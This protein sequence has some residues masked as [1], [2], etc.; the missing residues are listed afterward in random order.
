M[1]TSLQIEHMA[2]IDRV[3]LTP[4]QGFLVLSGETG[5]GKSIII[6]AVN[7]ALGERGSREVIRT[8]ETKAR[9]QALFTV[10]D[11]AVFTEHGIDCSDGEVLLSRELYQDGRSIF[12]INGELSTASAVR[13]IAPFLLNIHG[14]HDN[15]MLLQ[16]ARH[17]ELVDRF[18]HNRPLREAYRAA[19]DRAEELRRRLEE[20]GAALEQ[21]RRMQ[22]LYQYQSQEIEDAQLRPGEEAEL[23]EQ[24]RRLEHGETLRQSMDAAYEYLY[25]T[26]SAHDSLSRAADAL[27][28]V[29]EY[30]KALE[31]QMGMLEEARILLDEA[32]H[33]LHAYGEQLDYEPGALDQAQD[34]FMK[35][36]QLE[37]KY[38]G[39]EEAVIAYGKEIAE[40]LQAALEG[41]ETLAHLRQQLAEAEG[42][43]LQAAE[44]LTQSRQDAAA[45]L[46]GEV[47]AQLETLDMGKMRF[48]VQLTP[49]E[50][51]T[52]GAEKCVFLLSS[53][54]GEEPKELS[55]IASGGEL[56][57]IMLAM[58]SALTDADP[59][60]T[61]IFDEIDTGVSGRAA[62]KIAEKLYALSRHK[63]VLC[64]THLPQLAAMADQHFLVE[65]QEQDGRTK[66]QVSELDRE[67]RLRE[68]ARMIGGVTVTEL[69]AAAA[70]QMLRQAEEQKKHE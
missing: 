8:G 44:A 1:L 12:R 40:K 3:E 59:V 24:I 48:L 52:G 65:K 53:N 21:S 66:T 60:Q 36:R 54:P 63:Q 55:K 7:L 13:S 27:S 11:P 37:R 17:L 5:A 33:Q 69:T 18:A 61:L 32:A 58:K 67:K 15:Q 51:W 68:I 43:L 50:P 38:G 41:D 26:D 34:R 16:N 57:R 62:Q 30:D 46:E 25:G 4:G 28:R 39:T 49:C 45:R 10:D 35:I 64:V 31:E 9:V 14:Q 19:W 29:V 6:D 20:T 70:D 56:S 22:E 42:A 47:A 2:V 23:Q